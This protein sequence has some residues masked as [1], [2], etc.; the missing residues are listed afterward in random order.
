MRSLIVLC[1]FIAAC[2]PA[3]YNPPPGIPSVTPLVVVP[4][5]TAIV[6]SPTAVPVRLSPAT[7]V[8]VEATR[9]VVDT[10][11]LQAQIDAVLARYPADWH[12]LVKEVG[13]EM[14]YAHQYTREIDVASVIKIP[15]ALLFFKSLEQE[16]PASLKDYLAGN[17]IDGR[18]YEQLLH[19]MLVNSEEDATFS[20]IKAI[21]DSR[22]DVKKT[23]TGWGAAHTDIILRK[24]TPEDMAELI[25]GFY[26]HNLLTP[27][28]REILLA[29]MAEYTSA[30]DTRIGVLRTALPCGG[31]IY[32]KRGT[33]IT[34][35]LAVADLAILKFDSPAG[36]R[37]YTIVFFAYPGNYKGVTYE[38]LVQ[39]METL[40]TGFWQAIRT[41]NALPEQ[42]GCSA[43]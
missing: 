13:G 35:Y 29:Y 6:P 41:A 22:L 25:D 2:T 33:I 32:D 23:L 40:A 8:P 14:L 37:A 11:A 10:Q 19:A 21:S 12:I 1:V 20:L 18:T 39:G 7:Q 16:T 24:S 38:S 15:I 34:P 17:G 43:P 31:Q 30:D 27:A 9:P 26:A 5:H 28:A 42:T 3:S 4:A 36:E